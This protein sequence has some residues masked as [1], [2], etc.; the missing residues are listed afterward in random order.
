MFYTGLPNLH[1][2]KHFYLSIAHAVVHYPLLLT[3][4]Y[5]RECTLDQT[6]KFLFM[7]TC[8]SSTVPVYLSDFNTTLL[9]TDDGAVNDDRPGGG[10]SLMLPPSLDLERVFFFF[11]CFHFI[12]IDFFGLAAFEKY[13]CM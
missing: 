6:R 12:R 10:I 3:L 7:R 11:L 4:I 9:P 1:E 8:T 5:I 13:F 2:L